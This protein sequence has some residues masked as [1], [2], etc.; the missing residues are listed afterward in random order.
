VIGAVT[1]K[2][3]SR[4]DAEIAEKNLGDAALVCLNEN[5]V[6]Y[7]IVDSAYRVHTALGPGLLESVYEAAL[8][9]EIE[10]RGCRVIRQQSIPVV[11][12]EVHIHNGF[13]ADL[14]V[15]D[16][17][18]VEIKAVESVAPVHKRQLLTYLKLSDKRVGLLINFNVALIKD[19]IIRVVNGLKE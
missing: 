9:W 15:N 1:G 5:S 17:I 18:I 16:M 13:F 6:T 8:A 3:L 10:K 19:G 12:E 7:Q 14:I 2:N 4:R 11:Y